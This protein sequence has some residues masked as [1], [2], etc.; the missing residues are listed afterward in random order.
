[1]TLQAQTISAQNTAMLSRPY[2]TIHHRSEPRQLPSFI[3]RS[4]HTHK[5]ALMRLTFSDP[6]PQTTSA[7]PNQFRQDEPFFPG[8]LRRSLLQTS[9]FIHCQIQK[10]LN[11]V[12]T[13]HH[14]TSRVKTQIAATRLL[15]SDAFSKK[16]QSILDMFPIAWVNEQI[17]DSGTSI[18]SVPSD[19]RFE[20]SHSQD[21]L[22][23]QPVVSDTALNSEPSSSSI[24]LSVP[25][26]RK[27]TMN[28]TTDWLR[29]PAP[30]TPGSTTSSIAGTPTS[31]HGRTGTP[32]YQRKSTESSQKL[33][34][35]LPSNVNSLVHDLVWLQAP[36]GTDQ[37]RREVLTEET[38]GWNDN[39]SSTE[40][41]E[42]DEM[43][44]IVSLCGIPCVGLKE[45]RLDRVVYTL[46]RM[47]MSRKR[48][49]FS[50]L[51]IP[52]RSKFVRTNSSFN[53]LSV[54]APVD[55]T[56]ILFLRPNQTTP[57]PLPSPSPISAP[58]RPAITSKSSRHRFRHPHEKRGTPI[59]STPPKAVMSQFS[60][61]NEESVAD[62]IKR[63]MASS[64]VDHSLIE[65]LQ[66]E[67]TITQVLNNFCSESPERSVS[68][69]MGVLVHFLRSVSALLFHPLPHPILLH[70][71]HSFIF[72][73]NSSEISIFNPFRSSYAFHTRHNTVPSSS[74]TRSLIT[75]SDFFFLTSTVSVSSTTSS[76]PPVRDHSSTNSMGSARSLSSQ[77]SPVHQPLVMSNSV[78]RFFIVP[79]GPDQNT[80]KPHRP[81]NSSNPSRSLSSFPFLGSASLAWTVSSL[82]SL[83]CFH[84][85]PSVEECLQ[86]NHSLPLFTDS[87]FLNHHQLLHAV[88]LL[89][90]D[91][92]F[93]IDLVEAQSVFS[94]DFRRRQKE[95]NESEMFSGDSE[96]IDLSVARLAL[97]LSEILKCVIPVD[98]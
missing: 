97:R 64:V 39:E 23:T 26:V 33:P 8:S 49:L 77:N 38:D 1:M 10:S 92:Y 94:P 84:S 86:L 78:P 15:R 70:G 19:A 80:R 27:E 4:R 54:T 87:P 74:T 88:E 28:S 37:L 13:Q 85:V 63:S 3:S 43:L 93:L 45:D 60:V 95:M 98:S 12:L 40:M 83:P 75:D 56:H 41:D 62:L 59:S 20:F 2:R 73:S 9:P 90:Q 18:H 17:Q 89:K 52:K 14:I 29:R 53:G 58:S 42:N 31:A 7:T 76:L 36:G 68:A 72:D 16:L 57:I 30:R 47:K 69:S 22:I 91:L 67:T 6:V 61:G 24:S 5:Q 46:D 44:N 11:L 82:S 35:I 50:F 51:V 71:S 32:L 34:R 66:L 65:S 21:N 96:N 79:D 48:D 55:E 81:H 25:I